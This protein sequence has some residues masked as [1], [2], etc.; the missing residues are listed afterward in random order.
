M[1]SLIQAIVV[2]AVL[3][4]PAVSFAQ[5]NAPV[6]SGAVQGATAS[7]YGG[8][9]DGISASGSHHPLRSMARVF[10][11]MDHAI[12]SSIRPDAN[13]GMQPVYFGSSIRARV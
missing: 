10:H 13:D 2:S 1:K 11:R 5:S 12:R 6:S 7:S 4:V 8:A 3:A 9:A